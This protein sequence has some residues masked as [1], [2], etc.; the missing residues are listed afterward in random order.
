LSEN[1]SIDSERV[2][3]LEGNIFGVGVAL[4]EEVYHQ[5]WALSF[6]KLKLVLMAHCLF[7]LPMDPDVELSST[8]S[9]YIVPC[10]PP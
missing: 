7:L 8:M 5:W 2:A 3:L 1:S 10:F 4:L 6:Q 9:A